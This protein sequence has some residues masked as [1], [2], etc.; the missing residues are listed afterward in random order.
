[1]NFRFYPALVAGLAYYISMK[2]PE[3]I[4]RVPMLKQEYTEQFQLAAEEDRDKTS[5][6]FV[7][8]IV[9]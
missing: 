4:D 5:A 3:L 8:R 9:R 6:R 2:V 1:M 7:P